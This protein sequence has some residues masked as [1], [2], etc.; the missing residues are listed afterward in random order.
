ML[1]V[2]DLIRSGAEQSNMQSL[3]ELGNKYSCHDSTLSLQYTSCFHVLESM[4]YACVCACRFCFWFVSAPALW[5]LSVYWNPVVT[6]SSLVTHLCLIKSKRCVGRLF[7]LGVGPGSRF[8]IL[9]MDMPC[10]MLSPCPLT[11]VWNLGNGYWITP[12]KHHLW[13]AST[14]CSLQLQLIRMGSS[15]TFHSFRFQKRLKVEPLRKLEPLKFQEPWKD[16][17]KSS[18]GLQLQ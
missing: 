15:C 9:I 7:T 16:C 4:S 1:H 3:T 13:S 11:S 10:V 17:C 8:L 6:L 12:N 2:S 14:Y 18:D 5:S